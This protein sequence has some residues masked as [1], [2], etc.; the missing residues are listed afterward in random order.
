MTDSVRSSGVPSVP[1]RRADDL[2]ERIVML[3]AD[4]HAALV[5]SRISLRSRVSKPSFK[6]TA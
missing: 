4:M 2:L 1:L 3:K 6:P 5:L